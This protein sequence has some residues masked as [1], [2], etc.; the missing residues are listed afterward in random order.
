[1][2]EDDDNI[3]GIIIGMKPHAELFLYV[4]FLS[5]KTG[6]ISALVRTSKKLSVTAPDLFDYG[7]FT[8]KTGKAGNVCFL[9]N[10]DLIERFQHIG[11]HFRRLED[12]SLLCKII[13]LNAGHLESHATVTN[14]LLRA[15]KNINEG[16]DSKLVCLKMLYLLARDEGFPVREEWLAD[17]PLERKFPVESMLASSFGSDLDSNSV[18]SALDSLLR[19]LQQQDFKLS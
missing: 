16:K 17:L 4:Q 19:W 11:R 8:L 1:M 9:E 7:R 6:I 3:Y 12:A 5:E 2:I 10:F 18:A 13:R 14:L 15:L